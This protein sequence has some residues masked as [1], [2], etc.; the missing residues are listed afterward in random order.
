[1]SGKKK[2]RRGPHQD[3]YANKPRDPKPP[4]P[5]TQRSIESAN[6]HYP[7]Q[8][9][10]CSMSEDDHHWG[11]YPAVGH[12]FKYEPAQWEGARRSAEA[13]RERVLSSWNNR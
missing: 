3:K 10:V 9:A 1:V 8:C 4:P 5:R 6:G 7:A 11:R 13:E 12:S 2:E